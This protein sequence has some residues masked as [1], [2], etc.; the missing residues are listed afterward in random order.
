MADSYVCS[1]A[2]M[3]CTMG[4]QSAT[5]NVLPSRTVYLC[6]KPMANI[7]DHASMV[8]LAP[9]GKC[10]SL[11]YPATAAATAAAL[12]ALTPMPC[13]HN[14]PMPWIGGK[15]DYLIKNQP[16]LLK[17]CKCTCMWGGMISITDDGQKGEG[18]QKPEKEERTLFNTGL[19][20]NYPQKNTDY[21][22][23]KIENDNQLRISEEG[24]SRLYKK[25][26]DNLISRAKEIGDSVQNIAESVAMKYG[27]RCTPINYKTRDSIERKCKQDLEELNNIKD[28]VRTTI[29]VS[30]SPDEKLVMNQIIT[31]L[32]RFS[33]INRIKVQSTENDPLGYSGYIVNI[34]ADNGTFAEIQVN[35]ESM[36]YA[37]EKT[38]ELIIGTDAYNRIKSETGLECG[39]GHMLYEKWRKLP[40]DSEERKIIEKESIQYYSF[41][42]KK[43]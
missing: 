12:G 13:V 10:R 22:Y 28:F 2:T 23:P 17:S 35:T 6:G 11:A 38:A 30:D 18:P 20:N 29:V 21:Q 33:N 37:K 43:N 24:I 1:G 16:A 40:L 3:K 27:A 34:V 26:L 41:F 14:T 39:L 42:L 32:S 7:S 19:T 5:L 36:I 25:Q 31:E 15:S 8:N 9:F 4:D